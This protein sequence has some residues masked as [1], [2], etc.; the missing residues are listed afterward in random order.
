MRQGTICSVAGLLVEVVIAA[1]HPPYDSFFENWG[2]VIADS[3]VA[4][5]VGGEVRQIR[6]G[7]P[8]DRHSIKRRKRR[9]ETHNALP[10]LPF[11]FQA[12]NPAQRPSKADCEA[13]C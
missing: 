13:G 3:L 5:G 11:L 7:I 6:S 9:M 2:T 1:A 10:A 4:L 8:S 12:S